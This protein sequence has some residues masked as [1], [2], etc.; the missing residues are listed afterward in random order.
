MIEFVGQW[1]EKENAVCLRFLKRSLGVPECFEK[2]H[3]QKSP[4]F[5]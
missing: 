3:S 4:V 2:N 5:R 1:R